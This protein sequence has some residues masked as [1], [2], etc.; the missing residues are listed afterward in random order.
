MVK[1]ITQEWK[2]QHD[3]VE[4]IMSG[5]SYDYT[6]LEDGLTPWEREFVESVEIQSDNRKMLTDKQMDILERIYKEKS[7]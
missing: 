6:T 7:G 2:K 1:I 4:W 5:L 3:R